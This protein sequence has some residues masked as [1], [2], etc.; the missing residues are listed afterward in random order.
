M[1]TLATFHCVVSI[2]TAAAFLTA[3]GGS[4]SPTGATNPTSQTSAAA[5]QSDLLYASRSSAGTVSVFAFPSGQK[6]S[7]LTG[8]TNPE[9]LCSDASGNV[10][11]TTDSGFIYEYAHGGT[12]PIQSFSDPDSSQSGCAVDP[13]TGDLAVTNLHDSAGNGDVV[14]FHSG[15][16]KPKTSRFKN[17]AEFLYCAYDESG[18]LYASGETW[19]GLPFLVR[20]PK[21]G[22]KLELLKTSQPIWAR[23][24]QWVKNRLLI[25]AAT[26]KHTGAV[27]I[28]P[29][30]VSGDTGKV[31]APIQLQSAFGAFGFDQY[32]THSN[33]IVGSGR[34]DRKGALLFWNYP[35]GG[36]PI[37]AISSSS[38]DLFSGVTVSV[39]AR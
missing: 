7:E 18:N 8:I 9:G 13:T 14:V 17:T 30:A 24:I 11:V 16:Q 21:G 29:V 31:E 12:S 35:Q 27:S 10:Y 6:V 25:G 38:E 19:H 26:F 22:T 28:Y 36:K 39:G 32:W 2:T 37:K 20:L 15:S 34:V 1:R 5:T 4:A 3:C 23:S 33:V